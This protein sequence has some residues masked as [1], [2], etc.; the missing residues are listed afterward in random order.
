MFVDALL[1][2]DHN[3]L[4]SREC[5]L[6]G[7]QLHWTDRV[8]YDGK[9]YLTLEHNDTWTAH[10][11]QAVALKELWDQEMPRTRTERIQLQEGCVQLM[12]ELRLSDQQSGMFSSRHSENFKTFNMKFIF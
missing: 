11:P 9:V 8:F 2:E 4:R 3:I 5:I 1:S 7:P 12:K 6:E 10:V